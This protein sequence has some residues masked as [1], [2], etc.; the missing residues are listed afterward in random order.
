MGFQAIFALNFHSVICITTNSCF[1]MYSPCEICEKP[2]DNGSFFNFF[3]TLD[4]IWPKFWPKITPI[5]LGFFAGFQWNMLG[6]SIS[7]NNFNCNPVVLI[8]FFAKTS[9]IFGPNLRKKRSQYGSHPKQKHFFAEM[10]K[11]DHKISKTFYF[12]KILY[13]LAELWMFFY[14]VVM[15]FC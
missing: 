7:I 15:F 5:L 9:K 12:I 6:D 11:T 10:I 13:V 1:K 3:T 8:F 2:I 14:L 4:L